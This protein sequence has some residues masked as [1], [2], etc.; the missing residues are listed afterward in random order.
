MRKL[1]YFMGFTLML[2]CLAETEVAEAEETRSLTGEETEETSTT[3]TSTDSEYLDSELQVL[4]TNVLFDSSALP[5]AIAGA[6]PGFK[7]NGTQLISLQ[8]VVVAV[9]TQAVREILA[10]EIA[11]IQ[12]NSRI[13]ADNLQDAIEEATLDVTK[14]IEGTWDVDNVFP[15]DEIAE[16]ELATQVTFDETSATANGY[17]AMFGG[18]LNDNFSLSIDYEIINDG[19]LLSA[20]GDEWGS[21]GI[22]SVKVISKTKIQIQH[23]MHGYISVLTRIE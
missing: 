10:S 15:S 16:D 7:L 5:A 12:G 18:R 6:I 4:A 21:I 19:E 2:G 11:F 20:L 14:I 1:I 17:W 23:S 3:I 13:E 9:A 8:N 22:L